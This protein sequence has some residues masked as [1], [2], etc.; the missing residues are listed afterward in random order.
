MYTYV[1]AESPAEKVNYISIVGLSFQIWAAQTIKAEENLCG[2]FLF[3][4]S[5]GYAVED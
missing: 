5:S 1:D 4:V 2:N 3:G